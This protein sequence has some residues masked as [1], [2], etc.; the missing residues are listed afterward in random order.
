MKKRKIITIL[1]LS[2]LIVFVG[3]TYLKVEILTAL[4]GS[5]FEDLYN[6]SG[7]FVQ[8]KYF[9]VMDYSNQE[10]DVY[11]AGS[12][13]EKGMIDATFLYHF[14]KVNNEWKLDEWECIWAKY[15]SAD[16]FIW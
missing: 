11:Y 1:L 7:W 2:I 4:Y 16:E 13:D 12:Y 14:K 15:G 10:A 3:G 5:Q 9:K 8:S 6:A